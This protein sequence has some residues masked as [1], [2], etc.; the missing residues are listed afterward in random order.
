MH[1]IEER[2]ERGSVR[3]RAIG[4]AGVLGT[5]ATVALAG[6]GDINVDVHNLLP[7]TIITGNTYTLQ[8]G[9]AV[10]DSV[11]LVFS[12]NWGSGTGISLAAQ[13]DSSHGTPFQTNEGR[14][15]LNADSL[16][17]VIDAATINAN[18]LMSDSWAFTTNVAQIKAYDCGAGPTSNV[19]LGIG[20]HPDLRL[21]PGKTIY[22]RVYFAITDTIC[23]SNH[24]PVWEWQ[25]PSG[26][27]WRVDPVPGGDSVAWSHLFGDAVREGQE[28]GADYAAIVYPLADTTVTPIDENGDKLAIGRWYRWEWSFAVDSI[29]SGATDAAWGKMKYRLY[30]RDGNILYNERQWVPHSYA[31]LSD[32]TMAEWFD[33]YGQNLAIGSQG[34]A[35][36]RDTSFLNSDFHIGWEGRTGDTDNAD[37]NLGWFFG[38]MAFSTD[39]WIGDFIPCGG[40]AC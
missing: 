12:S 7:L 22:F 27:W 37:R 14:N 6:G 1:D 8:I 2:H 10:S 18:P 24:G 35:T 38:A 9:D 17:R 40:G 3:K 11:P 20:R 30:D 4:V 5:V 28:G 26:L 13:M 39:G 23:S 32:T 29:S 31:G 15:G 25:Q 16:F 34:T 21:V 33:D 36:P 19:N